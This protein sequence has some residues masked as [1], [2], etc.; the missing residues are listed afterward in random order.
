RGVYP[1]LHAVSATHPHELATP[2]ESCPI[3]EASFG[4]LRFE[5]TVE[6]RWNCRAEPESVEL[7]RRASRIREVRDRRAQLRHADLSLGM[8]T[9]HRLPLRRAHGRERKRAQCKNAPFGML[10]MQERALSVGIETGQVR[11]RGSGVAKT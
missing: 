6:H 3:V 10:E 9:E 7:P 4:N 1:Q 2:A 8:N 11:K 5:S